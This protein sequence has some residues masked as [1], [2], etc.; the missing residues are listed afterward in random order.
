[1]LLDCYV[2]TPLGAGDV[3]AIAHYAGVSASSVRRVL[4]RP[5]PV[6]RRLAFPKHLLV[7]LDRCP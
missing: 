4:S 6:S 5:H 3:A 2:A 7:Q 1:M